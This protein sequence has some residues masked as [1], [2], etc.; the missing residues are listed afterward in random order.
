[1]KGEVIGWSETDRSGLSLPDA[2]GCLWQLSAVNCYKASM[3]WC[4]ERKQMT[5]EVEC[6]VVDKSVQLPCPPS[7][8]AT[9]LVAVVNHKKLRETVSR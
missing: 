1:M 4:S 2:K 9:T 7:S 6:K 3:R 8:I 5:D